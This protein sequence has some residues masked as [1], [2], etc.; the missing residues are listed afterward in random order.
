MAKLA[1]TSDGREVIENEKKWRA[2][3][4]QSNQ[5][6]SVIKAKLG[7]APPDQK[8][9]LMDEW[10]AELNAQPEINRKLNELDKAAEQIVTQVRLD[11]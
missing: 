9:K 4:D 1:S 2:A 3:L 8:E 11:K 6:I 10:T 5:N 7:A